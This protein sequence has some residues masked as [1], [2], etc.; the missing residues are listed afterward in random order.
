MKKIKGPW[1]GYLWIGIWTAGLVWFLSVPFLNQREKIGLTIIWAVLVGAT[2][3]LLIK[4]YLANKRKPQKIAKPV[5]ALNAP[6]P[7]GSG[8]KYKRCC[9]AGRKA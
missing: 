2:V 3:Y 6:C 9:G 8:K 7:C 4:N 1:Y 5:F